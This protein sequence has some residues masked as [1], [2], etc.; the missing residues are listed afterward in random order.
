MDIFVFLLLVIA[1]IIFLPIIKA[2]AFILL[3]ALVL[4]F[5]FYR[6]RRNL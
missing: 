2:Y 6:G 1:F 5:L 4:Y 3:V